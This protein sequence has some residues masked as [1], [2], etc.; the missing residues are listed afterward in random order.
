MTWNVYAKKEKYLIKYS[1]KEVIF[2]KKDNKYCI[3]INIYMLIIAK[4]YLLNK[5]SFVVCSHYWYT[6]NLDVTSYVSFYNHQETRY[7]KSTYNYGQWRWRGASTHCDYSDESSTNRVKKCKEVSL[8]ER[9]SRPL[10]DE[11]TL[12][13]K[14]IC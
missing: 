1:D 6:I 3:C 8:V 13:L 9:L 14:H 12:Y 10:S 2:A 5:K 11:L 4:N 7:F